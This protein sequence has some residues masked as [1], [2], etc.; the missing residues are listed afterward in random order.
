MAGRLQER[1]F[2]A[3]EGQPLFH[4]L[5]AILLQKGPAFLHF[6]S[7]WVILFLVLISQPLLSLSQ[8]CSTQLLR[9]CNSSSS[10]NEKVYV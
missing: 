4:I 3:D 9:I 1:N 2:T 10:Y 5:N 7:T 6:T 8:C